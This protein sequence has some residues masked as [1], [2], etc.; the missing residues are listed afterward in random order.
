[1]T[2]GLNIAALLFLAAL[3]AVTISVGLWFLLGRPVLFGTAPW[4]AN[5]SFNLLKLALAIVGGVGGVA[6]LVIAY[7]KQKLGENA[8]IR[9]NVKAFSDRF[10]KAAEQLGSAK[11]PVRSAGVYALEHLA[12]DWREGRQTCIDELCA[13]LR[14]P[15]TP[16]EMR[17]KTR[18]MNVKMGRRGL[19]KPPAYVGPLRDPASIVPTVLDTHREAQQERQVRK[20]IVSVISG[21]LRGDAAVSWK[22]LNYDFSG[23]V[24][25]GGDFS[26]V[27]FGGG[28]VD[29]SG[30]RLV[31]EG[32]N[33]ASAK[34]GAG[35]VYFSGIELDGGHLNLSNSEFSGADVRF[36]S[37]K[38]TAGSVE[39]VGCK[40][41][42]GSILF[43]GSEFRG[44][45]VYFTGSK[46]LGGNVVFDYAEF[47]SGNVSFELISLDDGFLSFDQANFSGAEVSFKLSELAGGKLSFRGAAFDSGIVNFVESRFGGSKVDIS[48][49]D[50]WLSPPCFDSF[51]GGSTE[52]LLL[53]EDYSKSV[54]NVRDDGI[55]SFGRTLLDDAMLR[56]PFCL[57]DCTHVEHVYVSARC[58]DEVSTDFFV[59]AVAAR[60]ETNI[61]VEIPVG[62]S[63]GA[64][65]RQR[66]A[67]G[68][69]CEICGEDF[70]IIFTQHK[71]ATLVETSPHVPP[72][73][74][75]NK[76]A[77]DLTEEGF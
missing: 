5:D 52:G 4:T 61:S 49:V 24:F 54:S 48:Y 62:E 37:A 17:R 31:A 46:F 60:V 56:C 3:V 18:S 53:P 21:H 26:N 36:S 25:D 70:A 51:V 30:V 23:A 1:M 58:E 34:F 73:N 50:A 57:S 9:E 45:S 72:F 64:G 75:E 6:I 59:D 43:N 68:G 19:R 38:F 65:R 44:A 7:R 39:A 66:I 63:V 14:M 2:L 67:L 69:W 33:F 40:F 71:G 35:E 16:P 55:G 11:A 10:F 20:A 27:E 47:S 28:I 15:Y 29:F 74:F 41:V 13:Y 12:D 42:D 8:E 22:G 77:Q 76:V 32:L